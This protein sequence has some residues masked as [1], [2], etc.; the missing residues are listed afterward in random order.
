[1]LV[2]CPTSGD[3]NTE[4][5]SSILAHLGIPFDVV[6][7]DR[8]RLSRAHLWQGNHAHYQGI[9][10][11]TGGLG[12]WQPEDD[13][14][15]FALGEEQKELLTQYQTRF[16]I[17]QVTLFGLP[18]DSP[19]ECCLQISQPID[20]YGASQKVYLTEDALSIFDYLNPDVA[21]PVCS[22]A[23]FTALA[24]GDS[25]RP[26]LTNAAGD[27]MAALHRH[28][29]G[30]EQLTL[31]FAHRQEC[32]HTMLLGYGLIRWAAR[33]LFLGRRRVYLAL[34]VD[35][36]FNGSRLWDTKTLSHETGERF[37]L[38]ENDAGALL[39]WLTH[40]NGKRNCEDITLDLAF[41][42]ASI[43]GKDS[44]D[45]LA[46]TLLPQ[47]SRFRWI[48]HGYTH[49]SL[50]TAGQEESYVEITRNHELALRLGL[51]RYSAES[52]VTASLTGLKNPQFL[53]AAKAF[54]IR[55]L[56]S[57]TSQADGD[58]PSPNVG[59]V[60]PIEPTIM[61]IPRRP[62]NL[63]F[64]ASVPSEWVSQFNHQYHD[65][66]Q[67][68]L[69]IEEIIDYEAGVQL[70]NLLSYDLDP[71]MFHQANLRA[72]DGTHSLLSDLIDEVIRLYNHYCGDLPVISLGMYEIS[73]LMTMHSHLRHADVQL[74]LTIGS[75]LE[76]TAFQ[77]VQV[78]ITGA[79]VVGSTERY[80]GE[81]TAVLSL[82]P[83]A[84]FHIPM[85][86]LV[87]YQSSVQVNTE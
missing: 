14:W 46:L 23:A 43:E 1:M 34:H 55:Q 31:T 3:P 12:Y 79:N 27:T 20:T 78:P 86:H 45:P 19:E 65:L 28:P 75:G 53:A 69:T 38:D 74:T 63:F 15:V 84:P 83:D 42:G 61:L 24:T 9:I 21:I 22:V 71:W 67:R 76:I 87:G 64:S 56:I 81:Y 60:S 47:Q 70:V 49:L 57:D 4:A 80:A 5:I 44:S 7:A 37:R 26:L 32:L 17:R 66:W 51:T 39:R 50:D 40:L 54:G 73:R 48:N 29:D 59:I 16:G 77:D 13:R 82:S 85:D 18:T 36:I 68:D 52:M 25:T 58:N 41:N 6:V 72:Y 30:R 11:S 8:E 10:M 2:L 33:G 35:D 62:N